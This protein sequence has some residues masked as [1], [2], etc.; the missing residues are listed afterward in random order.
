M[1]CL[2]ENTF[3][4]LL[5]GTLD[6][7]RISDTHVHL[8][9]CRSCRELLSTLAQGMTPAGPG[10]AEPGSLSAAGSE[11]AMPHAIAP[12]TQVGRFIVQARIG[13]GGMGVV[14]AA[15]DPVLGRKVAL[16]L[17]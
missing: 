11:T 13:A 2:S 7:A 15:D 8:D 14:Y 6:V 9:T 1:D 17:I 16:K 12:G 5:D 10:P 4:Q 3:Q